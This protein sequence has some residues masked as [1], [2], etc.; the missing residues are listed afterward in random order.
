MF[1]SVI[2][3][4]FSVRSEQPQAFLRG[5][6]SIVEEEGKERSKG[7]REKQDM[8]E[9]SVEEGNPSTKVLCGAANGPSVLL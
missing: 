5:G 2:L 6:S 8:K 3:A 7:D 4:L 9:E 1:K